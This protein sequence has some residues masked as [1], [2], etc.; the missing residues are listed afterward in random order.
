MSR[1]YVLTP[2][3]HDAVEKFLE[4]VTWTSA[5]MMQHRLDATVTALPKGDIDVFA[6]HPRAVAAFVTGYA[7]EEDTTLVNDFVAAIERALS[8]GAAS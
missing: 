4:E 5:S 2:A 6:T 7:L 3:I 8:Q 1:N